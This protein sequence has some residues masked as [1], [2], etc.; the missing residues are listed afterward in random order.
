[1]NDRREAIVIFTRGPVRET[2]RKRLRSPERGREPEILD[3]I[4]TRLVGEA[5]RLPGADLVLA[6]PRGAALPAVRGAIRLDQ[7][8]DTFGQRLGTAVHQVFALGYRRVVVIGDDAPE[9]A[10]SDLRA[11]M[12]AVTGGGRRAALGP[13]PDGG[14]YLLAL[15]RH[16]AAAFEGIPWGSR[17]AAQITADHLAASGFR[18]TCLRRLSDIDGPSVPRSLCRRLRGASDRALRDLAS[19]IRALLRAVCT[20]PPRPAL[21]ATV[22]APISVPSPRG[23]P[24]S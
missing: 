19:R 11:A 3:R 9:V 2:H 18:V 15:N 14:Y 22:P 4:L 6:A 20:A 7:R 21:V 8:G 23:P 1:M 13:C 10:A 5:G 17:R 12:A 16:A 24:R